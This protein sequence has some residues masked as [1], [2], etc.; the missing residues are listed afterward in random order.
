MDERRGIDI[1]SR[2]TW[3]GAGWPSEPADD[4]WKFVAAGLYAGAVIQLIEQAY[5]Q[6][7]GAID[8]GA[9]FSL[10]RHRNFIDGLYDHQPITSATA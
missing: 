1:K 10:R 3:P 9:D 2:I 5:R 6:K 4:G 8:A 7:N